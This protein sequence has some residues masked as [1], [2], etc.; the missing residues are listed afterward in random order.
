M[1]SAVPLLLCALLIAAVAGQPVPA[2]A[3][4]AIIALLAKQYEASSWNQRSAT[5]PS[6]QAVELRLA[7][8]LNRPMAVRERARRCHGR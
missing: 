6:N 2:A 7:E 8:R 1:R 4:Y 3:R 5:W